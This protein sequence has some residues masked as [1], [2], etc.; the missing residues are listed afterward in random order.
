MGK[1][2][3]ASKSVQ[4]CTLGRRLDLCW[5]HEVD[6]AT[7]LAP[8]GGL[9]L[10]LPDQCRWRLRGWP[11]LRLVCVNYA[12]WQ[13]HEERFP[14]VRGP[15]K[16]ERYTTAMTMLARWR[17]I[18][19]RANRRFYSFNLAATMTAIFPNSDGIGRYS[20]IR[21]AK[22]CRKYTLVYERIWTPVNFCRTES[23]LQYRDIAIIN[24]SHVRERKLF[25]A[26]TVGQHCTKVRLSI[27]GLWDSWSVSVFQ[28][29]YAQRMNDLPYEFIF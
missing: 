21:G 11:L 17:E 16:A 14:D 12:N 18:D 28:L 29:T 26:L 5:F 20:E 1:P 4:N 7:I 9:K 25:I 8:V 22:R 2:S 24:H 3:D 27:V 23:R 13:S 15:L 6:T 19:I 10:F